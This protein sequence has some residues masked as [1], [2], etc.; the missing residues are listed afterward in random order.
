ML[1]LNCD[2]IK[3]AIT[4]Q[5]QFEVIKKLEKYRVKNRG[6]SVRGCTHLSHKLWSTF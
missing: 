6:N 1:N 3:S 2:I 4:A 5:L